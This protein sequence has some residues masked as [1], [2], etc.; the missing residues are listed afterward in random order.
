[1]IALR[2]DLATSRNMGE[3]PEERTIEGVAKLSL[4]LPDDLMDDLR[5]F[6]GGN[7]KAFV[8]A[9]IREAVNR[10]KEADRQHLRGLVRELEEQVGPVDE[11]QVARFAALL[12]EAKAA[13]T[14]EDYDADEDDNE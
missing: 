8:T 6:S 7:V 12:A 9:A 1:M 10:K 4:S 13:Q 3:E 11:A 2:S 5:G 14:P